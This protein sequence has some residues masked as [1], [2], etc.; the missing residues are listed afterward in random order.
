MHREEGEPEYTFAGKGQGFTKEIVRDLLANN[1]TGFIAIEPH[2]GKVFHTKEEASNP[3][4]AY[5]LYLEYGQQFEQLLKDCQI[6]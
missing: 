4:R 3:Q 1:Y 2:I 6:N 5:D